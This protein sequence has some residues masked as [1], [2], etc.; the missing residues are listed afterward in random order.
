M[1]I[2]AFCDKLKIMR[3]RK[4][5]IINSKKEIIPKTISWETILENN[6]KK[7]FWWYGG[8]TFFALGLTWV[9]L[10][11]KNYLFIIIIILGFILI[12]IITNTPNRKTKVVFDQKNLYLNK[13]QISFD[14][15]SA[16][17]F[18]TINNQETIILFYKNK[19]Q[20][21]FYLPLSEKMDKTAKAELKQMLLLS[22]LL[23]INDYQESWFDKL[24]SFLKL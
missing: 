8:I 18:L 24:Y 22:N 12:L 4:E 21:P 15:F 17:C 23:E 3:Q 19:W 13:N 10:L 1:R 9:A 16:F 2:T 5:K 20:P 14:R 6:P 11:M 7:N